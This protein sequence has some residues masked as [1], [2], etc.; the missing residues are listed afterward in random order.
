[1]TLGAAFIATMAGVAAVD[2]GFTGA[3]LLVA[4]KAEAFAPALALNAV[5]LIGLNVAVAYLLLRPVLPAFRHQPPPG[6]VRAA[7]RR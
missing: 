6:A 2:L 5:F 7:R 4:G 1:M 3:F